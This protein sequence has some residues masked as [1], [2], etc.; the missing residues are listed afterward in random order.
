MENTNK[1]TSSLF[2]KRRALTDSPWFWGHLFC[3]AGLIAIFLMQSKYGE[4]QAQLERQFQGRQHAVQKPAGEESNLAYSDEENTL[5]KLGPLFW[6]LVA[7]VM[8]T[9]SGLW[10]THFRRRSPA[11]V[12][13]RVAQN[14]AI[15]K[16]G[17]RSWRAFFSKIPGRLLLRGF[18]SLPPWVEAW[19]QT[20][21][22]G[23]L[24]GRDCRGASSP[25]YCW[26]SSDPL[27]RKA[28]ACR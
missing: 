14:V 25:A 13:R 11:D 21:K 10:W 1:I 5:I 3:V 23:L 17:K 9:W 16:E 24:V 7:G 27:L 8:G 6:L 18:C 2:R 15:R 19:L 20:G 26:W 4:R 22:N 28:S 12:A